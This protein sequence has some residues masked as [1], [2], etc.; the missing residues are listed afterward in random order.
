M[1]IV[2]RGSS[3]TLGNCP[4]TEAVREAA[5]NLKPIIVLAACD[6]AVTLEPGYVGSRGI[7]KAI[8]G[9]REGAITDFQAFIKLSNNQGEKG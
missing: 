3:E 9:D 8:A 2:G 7:A 5:V 6:K 4:E 1:F